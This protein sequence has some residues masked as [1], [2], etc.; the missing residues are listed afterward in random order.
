MTILFILLFFSALFIIYLWK[1]KA[2]WTQRASS[3]INK[4]IANSTQTRELIDFDE[5]SNS[6]EIVRTYLKRVLPEGSP[7][8][9][10]AVITQ[11]GG[12]RAKPDLK[13]WSL[14]QAEQ[15]FT[16]HPRS[17]VWNATISIF[18]GITISILDNYSNGKGIISGKLMSLFTVLHDSDQS[19]LN[20]A[21]LQR[22]LAESVW[23]PSALLPSQGIHWEETNPHMARASITDSGTTTSLDFEFNDSGEVVSVYTPGRY[24]EVSGQYIATPWKGTFSHYIN[25]DGYL[26]PQQ[27]QVE[28]HLNDQVFSY[29]QAKITGFRYD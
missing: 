2:Q 19:Q 23:F 21:S 1:I 13:Q 28:W 22:Y 10:R 16:T 25:I 14:M 5:L 9:S 27:A 15:L 3:L 29:W 6:P 8:I 18:P 4:T 11:Q 24:R 12:F 20:E 7:V 26:V 17:F